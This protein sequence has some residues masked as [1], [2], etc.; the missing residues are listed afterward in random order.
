MASLLQALWKTILRPN[1]QQFKLEFIA[2]NLSKIRH[3]EI[4]CGDYTESPH[5][6][7]TWFTDPP[8]VVGGKYYKY[9]SK[10]IDYEHLGNWCKQKEGQIIV[11]EAEGQ[12]WLPF[13]PLVS[14][15]GNRYLH[16]EVVWTN[17]T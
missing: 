12:N 17:E 13:V 7:A 11:C 16:K 10:H 2:N 3:W 15:R 8:Y 14:S 5:I 1:T 4:I 9:G 6:K